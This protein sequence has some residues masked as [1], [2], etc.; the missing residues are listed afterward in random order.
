MSDGSTGSGGIGSSASASIRTGQA[1]AALLL[2]LE[3]AYH[4]VE[5]P[6]LVLN[7]QGGSG[8][9]QRVFSTVAAQTPAG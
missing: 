1:N 6:G 9:S 2:G 4:A 7:L 8:E 5:K 3:N